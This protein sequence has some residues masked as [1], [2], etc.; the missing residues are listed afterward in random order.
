MQSRVTIEIDFEN[1]NRPVIQIL[2]RKSDDVR[3]NL[4]QS[5][6]Q[7]FGGQSSW[8]YVKW[9]QHILPIENANDGFQ[10]VFITPITADDF[11]N[12]ATVMLEQARIIKE[13]EMATPPSKQ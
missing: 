4:L 7:T 12:Q 8:A 3:D 1:N 5:F 2:F 9:V 6:L 10:R 11:E 13:Y